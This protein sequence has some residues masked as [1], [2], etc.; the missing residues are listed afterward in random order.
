MLNCSFGR[1]IYSLFW[2]VSYVVQRF[3]MIPF[4]QYFNNILFSILLPF[5]PVLSQKRHHTLS[6]IVKKENQFSF[7]YSFIFGAMAIIWDGTNH[8]A[9]VTLF[10]FGNH[11]LLT[12][13]VLCWTTYTGFVSFFLISHWLCCTITCK[14]KTTVFYMSA[15]SDF[16]RP[17]CVY[18][19]PVTMLIL[20][21]SHPF[22]NWN[23]KKK[24]FT[25]SRRDGRKRVAEIE[26]CA[27]GDDINIYYVL[28]LPKLVTI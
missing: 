12:C 26:L 3:K 13:Y 8:L 4:T 16:S 25:M 14:M 21:F 11:D 20:C 18:L 9:K 22:F 19:S 6:G 10:V 2:C 7:S 17:I 24:Y 1:F 28:C 15:R 5:P 23:G 27:D